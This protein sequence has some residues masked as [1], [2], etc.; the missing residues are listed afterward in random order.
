MLM[1]EKLNYKQII[2]APLAVNRRGDSFEYH[3]DWAYFSQQGYPPETLTVGIMIDATTPQ[4]G[5]M[6]MIPGSHRR[7]WPLR[8]EGPPLIE[9]GA[10][11]DSQGV[12]I[13]GDA[14]DVV[15]FHSKLV[16]A[17]ADNTTDAPRRLMLYSYH[18]SWHQ[19]EPDQ[20]NRGD[21]ARGQ[22]HEARYQELLRAGYVPRFTAPED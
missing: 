9:A 17:S 22:A 4:N 18:P 21:R 8:I 13:L 15:I 19:A 14:G 5:P 2:D 11:D 1:E 7:D 6:R 20:R 12:D 3:H 16:H 10:V